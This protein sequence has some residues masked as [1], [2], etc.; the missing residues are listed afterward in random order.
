MAAGRKRNV[1]CI[2]FTAC[3]RT[4]ARRWL[5]GTATALRGGALVMHCEA[6]G[7]RDYARLCVWPASL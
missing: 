7:D 1:R 3:R 5:S 6:H 2:A 4:P